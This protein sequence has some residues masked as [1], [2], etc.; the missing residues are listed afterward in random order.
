MDW[1]IVVSVVVGIGIVLGSLLL[2]IGIFGALFV[3]GIKKK[4][5]ASD[6]PAMPPC[7]AMMGG[8]QKE[9]A[10]PQPA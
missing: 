6:D 10:E 3:R 8:K 1:E 7:A 2:L 4:I 9:T 5:A